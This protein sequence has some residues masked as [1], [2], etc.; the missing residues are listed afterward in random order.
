MGFLG[1]LF[2]TDDAAEAAAAAAASNRKEGKAAYGD[3][4]TNWNPFYNAGVNAN[5]SLGNFLGLNGQGQQQQAFDNYTEGPGVSFM[6]D[7]GLRAL[8]NSASGAGLLN[9]GGA[10]KSAMRFGTGLAQQG[11]NS[12]L[13]RLTQQSGQG[14]QGA[15]ALTNARYGTAN[16]ITGANT[17]EGNAKANAS[18]AE[19][20]MLGGLL[21]SGIG[22]G[23]NIFSDPRLKLDI[24]EIGAT[25]NGLPWYSYRYVWDEP[26]TVREGLMATD[27]RKVMPWAVVVDPS[28]FDR[29]DYALAMGNQ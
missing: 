25:D 19:G 16:M 24:N 6:R 3:A 27:V 7:Q 1:G 9:S 2:G 29:V 12:F 8:D 28:G 14:M 4:Q 13:D 22:A 5:N 18:L 23:F 20:N 15:N 17:M 21:K 26:G 10:M 11:Y